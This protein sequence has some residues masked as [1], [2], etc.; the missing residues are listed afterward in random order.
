MTPSALTLPDFRLLRPLGRGDT[1]QVSLAQDPSGREVA[2][3]LP[4]PH[5]L[6]VHEAAE[7]FGN[8]VRLTLRLRHPHLVRGYAGVPFGP[9]A[10]LALEYYPDGTLSEVLSQRGSALSPRG[11][12][13][14][15]ADLA[16]ALTFLHGLGAVHQDVKPQNV[17]V[18]GG[19]AALGDLGSAYFATQGSKVS[20]SP[21]Y[22]AP[23]IYHGEASSGASDVYSLAVT[24]YELLTGA[25]P[26]GGRSY[27]ELMVSHLTRFPTPLAHTCP[28]LPRPLTRLIE[29]AFA[30]GAQDRPPAAELRRALL[31]S[32][33]EPPEEE[34]PLAPAG[35]DP[36]E[37]RPTGRHTPKP[38]PAA[39]PPAAESAPSGR[40]WN[41][42][43][44][45]HGR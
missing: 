15:L 9:G 22:M 25:R 44:R 5:T 11:R 3:K 37:A 24:A 33:G 16:S 32:L 23:E 40:R 42:F 29:Q 41:P 19:R 17:Y 30:K 2:L 36:A 28:D 21:Y 8:E 14:I 20:G 7:R 6:A 43:K 35:P 34:A 4:L 38:E 26:F 45:R 13:Q 39:T 18:A 12:L 27:E 10:F 1:S 31:L